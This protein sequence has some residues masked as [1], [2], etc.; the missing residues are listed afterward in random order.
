MSTRKPRSEDIADRYKQELAYAVK[1]IH[2]LKQ[3]VA[4]LGDACS[5]A[6]TDL[7]T[8]GKERFQFQRELTDARAACRELQRMLYEQQRNAEREATLRGYQR[9]YAHL[10]A[11]CRKP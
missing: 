8:I 9:F 10:E 7:A 2:I 1:Q 11:S 4:T 3:Q 5:R 6:A